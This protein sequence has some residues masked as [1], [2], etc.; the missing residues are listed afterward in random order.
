MS[1]RARVGCIFPALLTRVGC[2]FSALVTRYGGLYTA[3]TGEVVLC[4]QGDGTGEQSLSLEVFL[5]SLSVVFLVYV[6]RVSCGVFCGGAVRSLAGL[7]EG[8]TLLGTRF[9][10]RFSVRGGVLVSTT[11][12]CGVVE[13]NCIIVTC[14]ISASVALFSELGSYVKQKSACCGDGDVGVG[15]RK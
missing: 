10:L 11:S 2:V 7:G 12:S 6:L 14:G 4:P 5:V 8:E 13:S 3:C 9:V 15:D 1:L